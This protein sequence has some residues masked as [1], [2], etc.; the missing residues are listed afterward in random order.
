VRGYLHRRVGNAVLRQALIYAAAGV[1]ALLFL[2]LVWRAYSG[3]YGE[4]RYPRG[5]LEIVTASLIWWL[6]SIGCALILLGLRSAQRFCSFNRT[7]A[8]VDRGRRAFLGKTAGFAAAAPFAVSSYGILLERRRFQVEHFTIKVKGLA[9][10][11]ASLSIVHLTDIHVGPFMTA[12]QLRTYVEEANRLRPDLIAL[13]GDFIAGAEEEVLPCVEAL[14]GLTARY[15][16]FACLG[17]HDIA[18]GMAEQLS[19]LF[20]A[21]GIQMLVNDAATVAVGGWRVAVLGIDDLGDGRPDLRRAMAGAQN[22]PGELRILLSHRPEIF[23]A[24]AAQGIDLVIS[25]H[26]H[27]GQIKLLPELEGSSIARFLT[28]FP[29]GVFKLRAGGGDNG[30]DS[31]LFVGRGIGISGL[32]IRINCPPQIAHLTLTKD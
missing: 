13:T 23:P 18:A 1:L 11:S 3:L 4:W 12:A 29:E 9:P 30:K 16:V 26:Y 17:N 32:P 10:E 8:R 15:G 24:A 25:G 19:R 28:P 31:S 7:A 5:L 2:P 21:R 6:G 27:G 22:D 14:A 20:A